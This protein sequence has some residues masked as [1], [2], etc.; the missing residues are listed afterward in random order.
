MR[1]SLKTEVFNYGVHL[2]ADCVAEHERGIKTIKKRLGFEDKTIEEQIFQTMKKG[3]K[4]SISTEIPL[5]RKASLVLKNHKDYTYL[6][7]DSNLTDLDRLDTRLGGL[8]KMFSE[9]TSSIW[10]GNNFVIRTKTDNK[11][12]EEIY[13]AS[14]KKSLHIDL[15]SMNNETFIRIITSDSISDEDKKSYKKTIEEYINL[16]QKAFESGIYEMIEDIDC[17]IEPRFLTTE[18]KTAYNIYPANSLIFFLSPGNWKKYAC[19]WYSIE[20]L[21]QWIEKD[22]GPVLERKEA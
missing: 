2:F 6:Y 19:G 5:N 3:R 12:L 17:S 11:V 22:T 8:E 14:K 21:K 9:E 4:P 1:K 15:Y 7:T 18:F 13:K 20:E 16:Y 10:D